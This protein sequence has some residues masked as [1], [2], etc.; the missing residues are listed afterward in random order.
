MQSLN[1][2][3]FFPS[4]HVSFNFT[5]F[6]MYSSNEISFFCFGSS[7][8]KLMFQSCNLMHLQNHL[9]K[10]RRFHCHAYKLLTS[11]FYFFFCT[12]AAPH[13]FQPGEHTLSIT[14]PLG[15]FYRPC[16]KKKEKSSMKVCMANT[17]TETWQETK[18]GAE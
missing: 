7:A 17:Q 1:C 15:F 11:F 6:L 3:F 8:K 12:N 18:S 4:M 9:C 16:G 10:S 2:S 14:S 13:I 5:I